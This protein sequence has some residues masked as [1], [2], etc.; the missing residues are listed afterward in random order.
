MIID[1]KSIC[2][3]LII[4]SAALFYGLK[5]IRKFALQI[6][7]ENHDAVAAM[8]S[9][10]EKKRLKKERAADQAADA[11]FAKVDPILKVEIPSSNFTTVVAAAPPINSTVIKNNTGPVPTPPTSS[12]SALGDNTDGSTVNNSNQAAR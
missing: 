9:E 6:A 12:T 10:E 3:T 5:F 4:V 1:G 2:V 8:D 7:Q 11:A